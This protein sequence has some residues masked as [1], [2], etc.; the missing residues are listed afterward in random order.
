MPFDE[1]SLLSV[2]GCLYVNNIV[3]ATIWGWG[4]SSGHAYAATLVHTCS[5]NGF[6]R[7]WCSR[8]RRGGYALPA[9]RPRLCPARPAES[10][11]ISPLRLNYIPVSDFS[12]CVPLSSN[13]LS[14]RYFL[15]FRPRIISFQRYYLHVFVS[16]CPSICS[17]IQSYR[18]RSFMSVIHCLITLLYLFRPSRRFQLDE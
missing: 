14:H 1:K 18:F 13:P 7:V 11:P 5:D 2:V 12:L 9:A 3:N 4:K 15:P 6:R 8:G 10:R 17:V 16:V